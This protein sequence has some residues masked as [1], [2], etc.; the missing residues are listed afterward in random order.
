LIFEIGCWFATADWDEFTNLRQDLLL[1]L[2]RI[3][4]NSGATFSLPARALTFE[5]MRAANDS[6]GHGQPIAAITVQ[7]RGSQM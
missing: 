3:V 2:L 4:E 6:N 7:Q 5:S 1:G